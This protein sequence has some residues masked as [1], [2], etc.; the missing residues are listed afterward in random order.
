MVLAKQPKPENE[1]KKKMVG[2]K[3]TEETHKKLK[4]IAY[5]NEVTISD[6]FLKYLPEILAI[7]IK[8]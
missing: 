8:K 6:L 4:E 3:M 7:E 2:I 1:K 5:Y